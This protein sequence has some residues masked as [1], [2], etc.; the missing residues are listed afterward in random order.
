M[1]DRSPAGIPGLLVTKRIR[2]EGFIVLDYADKNEAA[3]ADLTAW[4]KSG[5][6]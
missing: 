5:K 4:S 1:I 3:A 6:L 2:M